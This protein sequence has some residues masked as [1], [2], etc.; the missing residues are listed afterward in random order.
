M[1]EMTLAYITEIEVAEW[2]KAT[3]AHVGIAFLV[4]LLLLSVVAFGVDSLINR[5]KGR[6]K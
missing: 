3:P 5:F 4:I 6:G 1:G 2:L